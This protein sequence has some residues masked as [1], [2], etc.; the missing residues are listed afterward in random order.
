MLVWKTYFGTAPNFQAQNGLMSLR[1]WWRS[2]RSLIKFIAFR[3]ARGHRESK[4]EERDDNR[5]NPLLH[6]CPPDIRSSRRRIAL[7]MPPHPA[8]GAEAGRSGES[9][10][11]RGRIP[12]SF[13][14]IQRKPRS[15][16]LSHSPTRFCAKPPW[17]E[18]ALP[19]PSYKIAGWPS[20]TPEAE[21]HPE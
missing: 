21:T 14:A 10:V 17:T 7:I 2:V 1:S 8:R 12:S 15:P 18:T 5:L 6:L 16:G 19:S 4:A 13:S 11:R 3:L 9:V 20:S